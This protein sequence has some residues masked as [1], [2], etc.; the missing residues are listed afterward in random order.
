MTTNRWRYLR[1]E[2]NRIPGRFDREMS[3]WSLESIG[4]VALGTRINCLD[5]NL[6][7]DSRVTKLIECTHEF[8]KIS[9]ELDYKP[10]LWRYYPTRT[11]KKA[12]KVYEDIDR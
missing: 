9:D 7:K 8:I 4:V 12:M 2:N 11:F 10:S 6:S 3:L 5:L 1:D